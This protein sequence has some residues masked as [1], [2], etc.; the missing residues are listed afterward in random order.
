V[1]FTQPFEPLIVPALDYRAVSGMAWE[2][3]CEAIK[4]AL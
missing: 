1:G 2:V 4:E 3:F